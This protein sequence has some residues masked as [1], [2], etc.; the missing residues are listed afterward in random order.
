MVDAVANAFNSLVES[1]LENVVQPQL[2]SDPDA[3]QLDLELGLTDAINDSFESQRDAWMEHLLGY[4]LVLAAALLFVVVVIVTGC[5]V[6]CCKCCKCC[7][8]KCRKD[9]SLRDGVCSKCA[10]TCCSLL[11]L[12]ITILLL[13]CATTCAYTTV[14]IWRQTDA[15]DGAISSMTSELLNVVEYTN[16][17]LK[18]INDVIV[19]AFDDVYDDVTNTLDTM[20]A[21][22]LESLEDATSMESHLQELQTFTSQIESLEQTLTDVTTLVTFMD[23]QTQTLEQDLA[24]LCASVI[25]DAGL[26]VGTYRECDVTLAMAQQMEVVVDYSLLPSLDAAVTSLQQAQT[27]DVDG[28]T[29]D[30]LAKYA[31]IANDVDAAFATTSADVINTLNVLDASLAVGANQ[32]QTFVPQMSFDDAIDTLSDVT[33]DVDTY[34]SYWFFA[35]LALCA[36]LFIIVF[37]FFFALCC[38]CCCR[39][40]SPNH[41]GSVRSTRSASRC[42]TCASTL[43]FAFAWFHML[44]CML[45]FLSGGLAHNEICRYISPFTST[46]PALKAIETLYPDTPTETVTLTSLVSG[47]EN[48]E[49]LYELLHLNSTDFD[50]STYCD[51]SAFDQAVSDFCA[52]VVVTDLDIFTN[53]LNSSLVALSQGLATIE[54]ATYYDVMATSVTSVDLQEFVTQLEATAVATQ[55]FALLSARF[56]DYAQ[57]AQ[58]LYDGAVVTI[59][60]NA[61]DVTTNMQSVEAV[62]SEADLSNLMR[63]LLQAQATL[64]TSGSDIISA[65]ASDTCADVNSTVYTYAE[66]TA[67][68]V[69]DDIGACRAVFDALADTVSVACDDFLDPYNA[70]WFSQ[71]LLLLL[72]LPS[73]AI[74][75]KLARLFRNTHRHGSVEQCVPADDVSTPADGSTVELQ[76][77]SQDTVSSRA[78]IE[79]NC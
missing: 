48:D 33:S 34:G 15:E 37:S 42:L 57:Q 74:S 43:T 75:R 23:L 1:F 9:E 60:Q 5:V 17:T 50:F 72:L 56:A 3:P 36:I 64:D 51:L 44:F 58:T 24:T 47:C 62:T 77:T 66:D 53:S 31:A 54:Y 2:W 63:D 73:V 26:C 19:V 68:A 35:S 40:P 78:S 59:E 27:D 71:M 13:I 25:T 6:C 79:S 12:F 46:S 16:G 49:S 21:G 41:T 11:L 39:L 7:K 20:G 14:Q 28:Q 76:V 32:L 30:A 10:R 67:D 8:N 65:Y 22:A 55:D 70:L 52:V 69:R 61:A 4:I 38:A 18:E 45:Y 29:T